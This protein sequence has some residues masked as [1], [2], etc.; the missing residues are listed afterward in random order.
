M[1]LPAPRVAS[2]ENS[3][4]SLYEVFPRGDPGPQLHPPVACSL[5][6]ISY[7]PHLYP[8]PALSVGFSSSPASPASR[9]AVRS[10]QVLVV[11]SDAAARIYDRDGRTARLESELPG[12]ERS[13]GF[14]RS[15]AEREGGGGKVRTLH[16]FMEASELLEEHIEE[17]IYLWR[18][19]DPTN[20][21]VFQGVS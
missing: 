3:C 17:C 21:S 4:T 8:L 9:P 11:C 18:K 16:P 1:R 6:T 2:A 10:G 14:G 12:S 7:H 5:K 13:D 19:M 20:L 15:D